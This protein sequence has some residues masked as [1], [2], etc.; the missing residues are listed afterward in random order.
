M[1]GERISEVKKETP[2]WRF[3]EFLSSFLPSLGSFEC[4]VLKRLS[5]ENIDFD[6]DDTTYHF[7]IVRGLFVPKEGE[8][9]SLMF[10]ILQDTGLAPEQVQSVKI[11]A[12]KVAD[13][14]MNV[15]TKRDV[16]RIWLKLDDGCQAV[17]TA[18]LDKEPVQHIDESPSLEEAETLR[19]VNT[20]KAWCVQKLYG[21]TVIKDIHGLRGLIC[22]EYLDGT[23]LGNYVIDRE[24]TV[25]T[26]GADCIPRIAES[27][28]D[29]LINALDTIGG[30]PRDSNMFNV[31]VCT[32]NGFH[33]RYCDVESIRKDT[34]GIVQEINML[35]SD[36]GPFGKEIILKLKKRFQELPL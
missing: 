15:G 22:K 24:E 19:G 3:R 5:F 27:V 9:T 35:A 31:I 18:S 13:I 21:S 1:S 14:S 16:D 2:H 8:E 11:E 33:T 25:R 10:R 6:R 20:D 30:V 28:T 4:E 23:M 17:M 12:F 26:H 7:D 32:N 29:M 34:N 36:F